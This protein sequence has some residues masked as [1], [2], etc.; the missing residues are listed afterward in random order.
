MEGSNLCY[1]MDSGQL[2]VFLNGGTEFGCPEDHV[3]VSITFC[4]PG[5]D[6][7]T[8]QSERKLKGASTE[9]RRW[10]STSGF[11]VRWVLHPAFSSCLNLFGWVIGTEPLFPLTGYCSPR[12]CKSL[13][14]E[15]VCLHTCES[16]RTN[17]GVSSILP[18]CGLDTK[19]WS[20]ALVVSNSTLWSSSFL[21]VWF[22]WQGNSGFV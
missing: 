19:F 22:C 14:S 17:C 7:R 5:G 2:G 15:C 8:S 16:Q 3:T 9:D 12:G 20:S 1:E 6:E 11:L 13:S 18:P 21:F 10:A 4:N